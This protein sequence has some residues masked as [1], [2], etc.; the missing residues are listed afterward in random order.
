MNRKYMDRFNEIKGEG[1]YKYF[2]TGSDTS[3]RIIKEASAN[4]VEELWEELERL[5]ELDTEKIS[6]DFEVYDGDT[7]ET[8]FI[9]FTKTLDLIDKYL[10]TS[11]NF[12][13]NMKSWYD[14]ELVE[15]NAEEEERIRNV[16]L[17]SFTPIGE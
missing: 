2:L 12:Y 11:N 10:K 17:E 16:L 1:Y 5:G 6:D 15:G 9:K 4:T 8:Y 14:I 7:E 3:G 13:Y